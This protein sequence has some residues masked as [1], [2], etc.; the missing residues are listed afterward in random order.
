MA[1]AAAGLAAARRR[2]GQVAQ[3]V[4]GGHGGRG[5]ILGGSRP[6]A[7]GC[8]SEAGNSTYWFQGSVGD[9]DSFGWGL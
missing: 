4:G 8:P 7:T 6:A 9:S 5:G 1:E 3:V 2:V